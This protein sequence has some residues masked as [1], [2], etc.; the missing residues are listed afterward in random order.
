MYSLVKSG[1]AA[2]K[3][4]DLDVD[5]VYIKSVNCTEGPRLKR[6]L[7]GSRGRAKPILKRM[8]HLNLIV[9][10]EIIETA[11]KPEKQDINKEKNPKS[12]IINPK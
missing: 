6:R 12:K 1:L 11:N 7:I 5:K 8:C 3:E 4:S 2:A 10:D 9:S